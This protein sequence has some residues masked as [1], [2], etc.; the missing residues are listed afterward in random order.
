AYEP[1][2]P[3]LEWWPRR[4]RRGDEDPARFAEDFFR[5][6]VGENSW[7]RLTETARAERRADGPAL[8]AELTSLRSQ[9]A[10]FDPTRLQMPAVLG[11]GELSVWHH[12]RGVEE[13]HRAISGSELVEV[14]GAGHGAHLSHPGA[15]A[16]LVRQLVERASP[17]HQAAG[18][19]RSPGHHLAD[20]RH[21]PVAPADD[22]DR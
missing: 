5:R 15:F 22:R 4:P 17:R 13:L 12:R 7:E 20:H 8:M 18:V 1:P 10:P 3:W 14:A 2:M 11:R 6:L 21:Q 9:R 19:R 16:E